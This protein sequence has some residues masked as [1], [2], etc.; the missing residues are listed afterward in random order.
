M[1]ALITGAEGFTGQYM[2]AEL[3]AAGH[4][5]H[6]LMR[7]EVALESA[8]FIHRVDLDDATH[9][10]EVLA[11][12]R[13]E[14]VVHLAGISFVPHSDVEQ[15][16]RANVIG[17]RNLLDA[18]ATMPDTPAKVLLPS[19]ANIYGGTTADAIAE[20]VLP[21]PPN[22]YAI[23]KLAMEH[24]ARL[25]ATRLPIVMTRPFNYTGVGQSDRFLVPK[26]MAHFRRRDAHIQLGNLDV[27]RDF[28]DVRVLV[29]YYR[30]LL[31]SSA[32]SGATVNVCSGKV[33][34]V[35]EI[36]AMGEEISGRQIRVEVDPAF[37][38]DDEIRTLMGN[39][40]LLHSLVGR[41]P[42]IEFRDTLR[43]MFERG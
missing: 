14:W 1:R 13:P 24:V 2:A 26:I 27:F 6:A 30:R 25:Y 39:P 31:E 7:D 28:L 9:L 33:W 32:A 23:S 37:V 35:R 17:T 10:R 8:R 22:D 34:S 16:Y 41:V 43:W 38:R 21:L 40:A 20:S 12:I 4:D 18:L 5:V 15:I 29:A 19:S 3:K 36:I 42:E 11:D